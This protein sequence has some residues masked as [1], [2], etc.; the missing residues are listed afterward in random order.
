[1]TRPKSAKLKR[2]DSL[3]LLPKRR[4]NKSRG[5]GLGDSVGSS[6][7]L[8]K[9]VTIH[10]FPLYPIPS[11]KTKIPSKPK[12]F[13]FARLEARLALAVAFAAI[14]FAVSAIFL[15]GRLKWQLGDSNTAVS[16]GQVQRRD[17][18]HLARTPILEVVHI[19]GKTS[20][21]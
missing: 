10:P 18:I 8:K 21:N 2:L 3:K 15:D 11:T 6:I 7:I 14:N 5:Q 1:M 4:K 16:A 20:L 9:I 17:I 12:V 19:L 13:L